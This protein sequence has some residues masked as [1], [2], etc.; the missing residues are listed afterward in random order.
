[1]MKEI[2]SVIEKA[3][4]P[5]SSELRDTIRFELKEDSK[6]EYLVHFSAPFT[7]A[8]KCVVPKG[9]VFTV[10]GCMRD[11]AFYIH[12]SEKEESYEEDELNKVMIEQVKRGRY[13]EMADRLQG[14]SFYITEEQLRTLP[15]EFQEG[16]KVHLLAII[17]YMKYRWQLL[18]PH[19]MIE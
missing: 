9:T 11:D 17:A 7:G 5:N 10:A 18:G 16:S 1:M 19:R 6:L 4:K 2:D 3:F 14:F 13:K 8:D 15:L 12:R